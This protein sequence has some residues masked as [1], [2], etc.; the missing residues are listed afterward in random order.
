MFCTGNI[1]D[2]KLAQDKLVLITANGLNLVK[3]EGI[4]DGSFTEFDVYDK[5]DGLNSF[6]V[7]NSWSELTDEGEL[8]EF[9]FSFKPGKVRS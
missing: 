2:I 5:N 3:L 8:L 4:L 1:F 7:A 9:T 6:S